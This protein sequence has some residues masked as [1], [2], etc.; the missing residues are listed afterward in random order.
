M[1]NSIK[2]IIKNTFLAKYFIY[3]KSFFLKPKSQN[4]EKKIIKHLVEK[5]SIPNIFV[6]FGFSGWEFNCA[7]LVDS[8]DGLLIDG[9]KYNVLIGSTIL[10]KNI[11]IKQ[12]WLTIENLSIVE[13]YC[14]GKKLGI[15]SI[16]V[17][18]NDFWFLKKLIPLNPCLLV[19]EYN[20]SFGLRNISTPYDPDFDR[21]KKHISHTYYGA[22][23]AALNT[24]AAMYG[25]AL[26]HV[27]DSGINSYFIRKDLLNDGDAISVKDAFKEKIFPDGRHACELWGDISE[28]EYIE[29][30][31]EICKPFIE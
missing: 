22:S 24:L 11:S 9:D 27:G 2:K 15:L 28:L 6:E 23:L 14:A 8:W 20:S 18:G 13:D 19:L 21:T 31:R 4:D 7:N 26:V 17:D 12:A 10:P 3:F 5:Y 25:Y 30:T 29:I 1:I 16:D